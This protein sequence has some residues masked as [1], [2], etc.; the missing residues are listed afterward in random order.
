MTTAITPSGQEY[1]EMSRPLSE[2][3]LRRI[4]IKNE[5]PP[6]LYAGVGRYRR[7]VTL[8]TDWAL[9]TVHMWPVKY[10]WDIRGDMYDHPQCKEI[11]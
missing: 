6:G 7:S 1:D 8:D 11:T 4:A 2:S 9:V 10:E 5:F 3:E